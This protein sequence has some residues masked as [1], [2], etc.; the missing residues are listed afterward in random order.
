MTQYKRIGIDT[1]D[2]P[3]R[4]RLIAPEV[5]EPEAAIRIHTDD[6]VWRDDWLARLCL[7]RWRGSNA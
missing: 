7:H 3:V 1:S 6:N 2:P 5:K 4:R